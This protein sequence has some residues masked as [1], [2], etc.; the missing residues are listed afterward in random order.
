MVDPS[1]PLLRIGRTDPHVRV[2]RPAGDITRSGCR[3]GK[4]AS[5]D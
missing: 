1:Q 3:T 5:S 4:N 2:G